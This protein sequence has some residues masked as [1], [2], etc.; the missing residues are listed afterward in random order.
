MSMHVAKC[1]AEEDGG[2]H[3]ERA[4]LRHQIVSCAIDPPLYVRALV[5]FGGRCGVWWL[6]WLK[7]GFRH[8]FAAVDDGTQWL[9]IDPLLHRLEVR[10]SGLASDFDLAAAY[11]RMGLV[12]IAVSPPAVPRR[13][14][15]FGLFTCVETVKRLLGL[16][17]VWVLTPWQLFRLLAHRSEPAAA[18]HNKENGIKQENI[19]DSAGDQI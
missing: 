8:C 19:L 4:N 12:V 10:A 17:G 11:R 18:M 15:V 5:V 3:V 2:N 16:R 13:A 1:L 6:R 7:P 14:A 9:T